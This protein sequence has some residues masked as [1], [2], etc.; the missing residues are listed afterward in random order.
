MPAPQTTR[1]TNTR[2]AQDDQKPK[3]YRQGKMTR[4]AK[5]QVFYVKGDPSYATGKAKS[6]TTTTPLFMTKQTKAMQVHRRPHI[7]SL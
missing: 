2:R 5:K 1:K 3:R 7:R 6:A 4:A